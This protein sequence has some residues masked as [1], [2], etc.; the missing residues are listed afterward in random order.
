[1]VQAVTTKQVLARKK[2]AILNFNREITIFGISLSDVYKES[3]LSVRNTLP[4]RS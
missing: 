3:R 2:T 1:M 4:Y